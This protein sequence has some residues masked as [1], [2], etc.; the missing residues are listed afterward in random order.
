MRITSRTRRRQEGNV[1][2]I[3]L[4]IGGIMVV[5]LASTLSMSSGSIR[6]AHGRADWNQ[7][8]YHAENA[9][10]WAAQRLV[11]ASPAAGSS[12]YYS[13]AKGTL[14]L[15]Y[16]VA[17][18]NGGSSVQGSGFKNAWVKVVQSSA[19]GNV[20]QITA[21][22][23]V[24]DKVRTVQAQVT[25]RPVSLVFDY[26]YF[27][28]NWGWW[29]G[30][31]ISGNGAQRANWDFDFR[32]NPLVNGFI[33]AA[34]QVE[35]NEV[36]FN[37]YTQSPPFRGSA[38]SDPLDLV[39]SGA[40]RVT[41]P[42]LLDFSNYVIT[43]MSNTSSNGLWVGTNQLVFG[44]QSNSAA[45]GLYV[46]GTS[47]Q[48]ITI[49]GTVVIP[50]DVVI[51]GKVEGQGTLYVG[52]NLYIAGDLT[53]VKG[54]DFSSPPETMPPS[55]RDTW[56]GQNASK[57]LVAYAVR[58]SIF[59][60]DVTCSDWVN[61]C[62]NFPGSGLQNVGDESHL[63][64]DGIAGTSDDNVPFPHSDGTMSTWYDADGD[65]KVEHNYDYN[66]DITMT[67]ARA[68]MILGYPAD[69]LG[70]PVAFNQVATDNMGAIDGV[71]YTDHAVAMRLANSTTVWH[72]TIVSRN[73]QIIFQNQLVLNYDSRI[74]SR[75]HNNPN[76]YINLG[77][78]FGKAVTVNKFAELP[79]DRS[80]L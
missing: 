23:K 72:G 42:N 62:Y 8:F 39:H 77:L 20:Y 1:L 36:P 34:D 70:A 54:P 58:G 79:P 50:G 16:M 49:S 11:D 26:E 44:V 46:V 15:D 66:A 69:N 55:Q 10:D 80:G 31:S 68:S 73:E 51:S 22:A 19:L 78:P 2:L 59:A 67:S 38:G 27:L 76:Q 74:H 12:N 53:Y 6:N 5:V 43:A 63:G 18:L 9:I 71:L 48:P 13:T 61:W 64:A 7:A 65:G 57:D 3:A 47:A 29:W 28:N 56:V 24:D 35:E 45:P 75:Y 32:D 21:S 14:T 52:G 25:A 30:S 17:A 33:Y 41:M 4:V 60:G 40:P 37:Q